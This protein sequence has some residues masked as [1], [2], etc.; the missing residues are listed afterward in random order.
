MFDNNT[1][2]NL[3]EKASSGYLTTRLGNNT[4][5]GQEMM[6]GSLRIWTWGLIGV[7]IGLLFYSYM[8]LTTIHSSTLGNRWKG[9]WMTRR[10]DGEE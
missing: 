8:A 10:I 1:P 9:L 3:S 6:K 7:A 2:A 5:Y 4:R